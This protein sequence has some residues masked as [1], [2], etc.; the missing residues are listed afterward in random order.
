[1]EIDRIGLVAATLHLERC[2][3]ALDALFRRLALARLR[4]LF[5]K[6]ATSH[7]GHDPFLLHLLAKSSEET[8]K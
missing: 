5:E 6:A 2:A 7:G 4:W 3:T 8:I 1:M